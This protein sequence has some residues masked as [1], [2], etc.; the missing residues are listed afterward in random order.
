M[1]GSW[2]VLPE[3]AAKVVCKEYKTYRSLYTHLRAGTEGEAERAIADLTVGKQR[4][5]PAKARKLRRVMMA[6][7]EQQSDSF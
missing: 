2:Q 6:T 3:S 1:R 5:G 4:L 7:A